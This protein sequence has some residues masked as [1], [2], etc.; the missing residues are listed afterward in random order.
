MQLEAYFG[1][2]RL[3]SPLLA[4]QVEHEVHPLIE[5]FGQKDLCFV[6]LQLAQAVQTAFGQLDEFLLFGHE[7]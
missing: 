3:C 5:Y 2:L 1:Q 6:A 4:V 7:L